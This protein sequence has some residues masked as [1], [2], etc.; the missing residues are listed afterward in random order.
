MDWNLLWLIAGVLSLLA[1]FLDL[2][3]EENRYETLKDLFLGIGSSHGTGEGSLSDW[4]SL[5]LQ[6]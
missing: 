3:T 4:C 6:G 1:F 5:Q 2:R